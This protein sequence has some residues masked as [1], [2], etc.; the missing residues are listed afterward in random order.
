MFSVRRA[1]WVF[2]L[3]VGVTCALTAAGGIDVRIDSARPLPWQVPQS[4]YGLFLED[5]SNGIDGG[6]YPELIRNRGFDFPS[7]DKDGRF[8]E[9][10]AKDCGDGSSCRVTL[11]YARPKF[12]NTP[13]Y[14]HVEAF[15]PDA[16]VR[17]L[18]VMDELSVRVGVPLE[19]RVWARGAAFRA[20]IGDEEGQSVASAELQPDSEW[21]L[22]TAT[23]VPDRDVKNARFTIRTRTAGE[24]DLEQVSLMPKERAKCGLRRDVV[25]LMADLHPKEL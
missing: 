10:W 11:A 13:A 15:A 19:L 20:A 12:T 4:L 22:C 5:I 18:G 17:N 2:S 14:L 6:L 3:L 21:T 8:P 23:L 9:G 1:V 24:L 25:K 16:G 7:F